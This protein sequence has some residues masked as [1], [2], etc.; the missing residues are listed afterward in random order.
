VPSLAVEQMAESSLSRKGS[1]PEF[2]QV[3]AVPLS[4]RLRTWIGQYT[5]RH[6]K[7]P[8]RRAIYL[9]GQE[10]AKDTRRPKAE[11]TRMAGGTDTGHL[12]SDK[13]G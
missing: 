5:A 3:S 11:A 4:V 12:V 1:G 2:G 6:G 13:S 8:G 9:M 10:I 7:P